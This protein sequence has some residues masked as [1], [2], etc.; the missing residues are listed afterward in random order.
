M[1]P[2]RRPTRGGVAAGAL[3]SREPSC[4]VIWNATTHGRSGVVL[5][6]VTAVAIGVSR[7]EIVIVVGVARRAGCGGVRAR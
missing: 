6:L 3:R 5:I 7:S 1:A 2:G 4:H